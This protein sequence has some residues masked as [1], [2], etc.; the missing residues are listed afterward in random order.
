MA[1]ALFA[2]LCLV[3]S[4]A[5]AA[6][7][8]RFLSQQALSSGERVTVAEGDFEVGSVGSY[9]VRLY[10]AAKEMRFSSGLILP[11]DGRIEQ[12][13]VSDIDA[14]GEDEVIVVLRSA[15]SG[16]DRSAQTFDVSDGQVAPFVSLTDLA[17]DADLM[18]A[19]RDKATLHEGLRQRQAARVKK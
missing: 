7:P 3:A 11:R 5:Q 13:M 4:C 2:A 6:E 12:V 19:L 14:D 18:A 17:P 9:S 1:R 8:A 15:G 16:S 10:S